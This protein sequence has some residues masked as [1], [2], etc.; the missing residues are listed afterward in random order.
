MEDVK[1]TDTGAETEAII[2]VKKWL[3]TFLI[4]LIPLVNIIMLFVW[5]YGGGSKTKANFAKG[6]LLMML[7]GI[8]IYTLL[9]A[10]LISLGVF[11]NF[12][13]PEF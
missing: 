9:I 11:A 4:L 7:V 10:L 1:V 3:I 2:S 12:S 6:Y 8:V 13:M 5:A